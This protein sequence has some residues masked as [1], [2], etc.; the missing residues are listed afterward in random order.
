MKCPYCRK[1][2]TRVIDS[3]TANRGFI[4]RRRRS[5]MSCKRRFTTYERPERKSIRVIKRDGSREPFDWTKIRESIAIACNKRPVSEA[6]ID[7]AAN[8]VEAALLR[9][10]PKE[11]A[12]SSIG[13]L[14]LA[15]LKKLDKVAYVRYASVFRGFADVEQFIKEAARIRKR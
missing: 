14:V 9:D 7:K 3:R 12:S 8:R 5:C 13:E 4:I 6:Q 11:I 10:Q 1:D 15:E 2:A